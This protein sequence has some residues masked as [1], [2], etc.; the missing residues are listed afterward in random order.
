MDEKCRLRPSR[1][2]RASQ[3]DAADADSEPLLL[4]AQQY[5]V[6]RLAMTAR[7]RAAVIQLRDQGRI[8]DAVLRQ[9]QARLD[10]EELRLSNPKP[11]D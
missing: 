7:K 5:T 8:D 10:I 6:L 11:I 2:V 3:V 1:S 9:V 4:H